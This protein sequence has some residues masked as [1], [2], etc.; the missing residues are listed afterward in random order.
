MESH[1]ISHSISYHTLEKFIFGKAV[2]HNVFE[3]GA[4]VTQHL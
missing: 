4:V 3:L 1:S 2:L